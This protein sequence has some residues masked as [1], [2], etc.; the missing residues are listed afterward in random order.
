MQ[1]HA[2]FI[3]GP[4]Q[5]AQYEAAILSCTGLHMTVSYRYP[6]QAR[7]TILRGNRNPTQCGAIARI[8]DLTMEI[9]Q[10]LALSQHK[11]MVSC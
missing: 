10:P 7:E 9:E 3:G 4:G 5:A 11:R 8:D 2:P 1:S 6:A